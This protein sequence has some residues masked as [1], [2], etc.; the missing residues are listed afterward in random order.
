MPQI[1]TVAPPATTI[2][3]APAVNW[4]QFTAHYCQMCRW[5]RQPI[6]YTGLAKAIR[7]THHLPWGQCFRIAQLYSDAWLKLEEMN[8]RARQRM[9]VTQ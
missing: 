9:G 6:H 2:P 8:A 5:F 7:D 1:N 4:S 3:P